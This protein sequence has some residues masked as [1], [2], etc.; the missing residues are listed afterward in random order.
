MT[1]PTDVDGAP[2]TRSGEEHPV[3][4]AERVFGHFGLDYYTPSAS[5][6]GRR[7]VRR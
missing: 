2:T 6:S 3:E 7:L 4:D 1:A 5:T